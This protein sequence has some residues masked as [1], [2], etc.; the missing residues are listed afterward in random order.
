[1]RQRSEFRSQDMFPHHIFTIMTPYHQF[2]LLHLDFLICLSL[3]RSRA[4]WSATWCIFW[5][6][7]R[8]RVR[9]DVEDEIRVLGIEFIVA[10]E[11]LDFPYEL[12]STELSLV[13]EEKV[14]GSKTIG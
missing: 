9:I 14:S 8:R 3:R 1:M 13:L 11:D 2:W 10:L 5:Q 12:G 6:R 7:R 4:L